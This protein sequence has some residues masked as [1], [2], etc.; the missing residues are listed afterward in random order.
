VAVLTH[1]KDVL[2]RAHDRGIFRRRTEVLSEWLVDMLPQEATRLLDV[3]SGDGTIAAMVRDQRPGTVVEGVDV[4]IR[5]QTVIPV[6]WFD[7]TTL[8]FADREVDVVTLIDV[9][10]HVDDPRQ[11]LAEGLRV[12]RHGVIIKDHFRQG[13]LAHRR[14]SLMDWVGN[15]G[16]GVR[17]PYGYLSPKE[18]AELYE[19]VGTHPLRVETEL[20]LYPA[21][22]RPLFENGLHFIARLA[23]LAA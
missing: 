11:L 18:W 5:P 16:H 13:P 14:L 15:R 7:G 12:A 8:P 6:R 9:L 20:G 2:N 22:V 17:L 4:L 19:T 3:G 21:P 10:H 1:A 23:P